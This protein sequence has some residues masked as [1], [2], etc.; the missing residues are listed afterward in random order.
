[1]SDKIIQFPGAAGRTPAP[2]KTPTPKPEVPPAGLDAEQLRQAQAALGN[3]SEDQ[4]KAL[5]IVMSGMPFVLVGIKPTDR[6][7]DFFTALHG[8][9][10]DLRNAQPHL[11]GVI[12]RAYGRKGV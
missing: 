2:I 4:Q 12:A 5:Q 10:A 3:L 7:A 6:G 1:M 9:D 8:E 11:D